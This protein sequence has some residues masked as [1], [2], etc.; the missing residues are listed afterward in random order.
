MQPAAGAEPGGWCRAPMCRAFC[1]ATPES[2]SRLLGRRAATS[3]AQRC[4]RRY[5][6][7]GPP[8][9][10]YAACGAVPLLGDLPER[11]WV[12]AAEAS[13]AIAKG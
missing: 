5:L 4:I 10:L 8:R 7:R 11:R 6:V 2:G 1:L 9:R 3:A 12:G 13:R